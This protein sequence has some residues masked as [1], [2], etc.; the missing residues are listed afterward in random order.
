MAKD[1]PGFAP[2]FSQTPFEAIDLI[3]QSGGLAVMA[4][5]MLTQKDELI[6]RLA[7]YGMDG[8][9]VFYPNCMP[10]VISFYE[11]LAKKHG[12]LATGGSDAHWAAKVYTYIGK[13]SIPYET[14]EQMKQKL[15]HVQ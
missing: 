4:H 8:L 11:K 2:K 9:E 10:N 7:K 12:L 1:R 15:S 5:P 6:S 14:V 3:H 13:A